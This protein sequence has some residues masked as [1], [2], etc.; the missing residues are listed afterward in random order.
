MAQKPSRK[1]LLN[2][3]ARD[4]RGPDTN[5]RRILKSG[6]A[7]VLASAAGLGSV[8]TASASDESDNF[9]VIQKTASQKRLKEA[10]PIIKELASKGLISRASVSAFPTAPLGKNESGSAVLKYGE[11]VVHTF[12]IRSDGTKLTVNLP[13]DGDPYAIYALD[14][15]GPGKRI[16]FDQI[17]G[18]I[19]TT[20]MEYTRDISAKSNCSGTCGGSTCSP[21]GNCWWEKRKCFESCQQNSAG[22]WYCHEN[23][24]CGC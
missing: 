24:Q 23:C 19:E 17:K 10:E 22:D 9:E 15:S 6:A 18:A 7:A 21:A 14:G 20:K 1:Q 11:Q 4:E 12:V 13:E 5:R 8:G 3:V 2:S 16:R